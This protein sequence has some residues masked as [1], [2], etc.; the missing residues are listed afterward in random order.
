MVE[1]QVSWEQL[2]QNLQARI[3]RLED[4]NLILVALPLE[5]AH[6]DAPKLSQA[7]GG[8]YIDFD[9]ELIQRLEEDNWEDH[10]LLAKRGNLEP[11]RSIVTVLLNDVI[12]QLNKISPIVIGNPN[13]AAFYEIDLAAYLYSRTRSGHCVLALPGRV[14]GETLLLHGLYP[15][16]GSGF[17]PVLE[18]I[19]E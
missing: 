4:Y 17:T 5:S 19:G 10:I 16:T 8:H 2:I 12:E 15:Q 13:L 11:G 14:K 18:L 3:S 7:I 6:K 9:R 1:A